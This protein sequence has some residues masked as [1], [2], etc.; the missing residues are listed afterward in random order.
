VTSWGAEVKDKD[1]GV[2]HLPA[3]WM[4]VSSF[5]D[6]L[7]DPHPTLAPH[8]RGKVKLHGA[9]PL[10]CVAPSFEGSPASSAT[11]GASRASAASS[12]RRFRT[13]CARSRARRPR[14]S[15]AARGKKLACAVTAKNAGGDWTVFSK[16]VAG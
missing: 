6:F 14:T 15:R 12:S 11:A 4:R 3:V 2:A 1:C 10:T 13:R 5:H 9:R 7:A 16:S 8:T